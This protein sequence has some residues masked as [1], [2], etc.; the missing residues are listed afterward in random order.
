MR[1]QILCL[2]ALLALSTSVLAHVGSID[3]ECQTYGFDFGIARWGYDYGHFE[4]EEHV[5][6]YTTH[7]TGDDDA[8]SWTAN[9]EVS[10]VLVKS[11]T[12]TTVFPGGTSG[13]LV[14]YTHHGISHV[15]FCGKY[16]EVPEFGTITALLALG[17]AMT[18]FFVLRRK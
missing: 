17:G 14:G 15:T 2:V 1:K 18:G 3:E 12:N 10:G 11:S 9:P 16:E 4:L 7:V 13:N 6:N 5:G 8:A